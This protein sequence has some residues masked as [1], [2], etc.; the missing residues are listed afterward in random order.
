MRYL[1]GLIFLVLSIPAFANAFIASQVT[2]IDVG[3]G[4]DTALIFLRSGEV[5]KLKSNDQFTISAIRDAIQQKSWVKFS[6]D[7]ERFIESLQSI[8]SPAPEGLS[9]NQEELL[10]FEPTVL[11]NF[12]EANRI[13]KSFNPDYRWRSQ[14]YNR[15]HIWSYE[16]F[17]KFGFNSMKVFLFFTRKYI[18]EYNY[19]WWFHVSPFTYVMEEGVAV[20]KVLD[21]EFIRKPY[22]M[23]DW[24]DIFMKNDANCPVVQKYSDYSQHE[25][26]AYCYLFKTSMYYYQ[27][28]DLEQLETL[29]QIKTDWID[30][31][32]D[33]AYRQGFGR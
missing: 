1:L 29:G 26:E 5:L 4:N 15:A 25:Q 8:S 14:C 10:S 32:I 20:E 6:V 19:K 24:T 28:K 17:K 2:E 33:Q 31:E 3:P 23:K 16:S 12:D 21:Y 22:N 27:P 11:E 13:F 18:R 7:E 9:E 30:G